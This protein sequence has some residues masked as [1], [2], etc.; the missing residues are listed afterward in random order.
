MTRRSET[1]YEDRFVQCRVP[2]RVGEILDLL[3]LWKSVSKSQI[4]RNK[5]ME[6]TRIDPA[7]LQIVIKDVAN[8]IISIWVTKGKP[9]YN[10]WR[11][12][13]VQ[14]LKMKRKISPNFLRMI[15]DEVDLQYDT[16]Y[17]RQQDAFETTNA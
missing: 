9:K 10:K 14:E 6:A 1:L 11:P 4:I 15:M 13:I 5:V 17:K 3:A 7:Q 16:V 8:R 2:L 12:Q